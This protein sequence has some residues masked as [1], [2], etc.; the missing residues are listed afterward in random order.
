M[1][2]SSVLFET[3]DKFLNQI[4]QIILTNYWTTKS[5]FIHEKFIMKFI[6]VLL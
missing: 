1:C 2:D 3:F 6:I 4:Y 5:F